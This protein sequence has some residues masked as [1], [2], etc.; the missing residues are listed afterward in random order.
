MRLTVTDEDGFTSE[1][2]AACEK[3]PSRD[4]ARG[5]LR[6]GEAPGRARGHSYSTPFGGTG[7]FFA[8]SSRVLALTRVTRW[9]LA[10]ERRNIPLP[11]QAAPGGADLCSAGAEWSC[12]P[13]FML[14]AVV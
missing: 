13:C 8:G 4:P 3:L 5:R 11:R 1:A 2:A 12:G 6:F 10:M 9:G 14:G 7:M